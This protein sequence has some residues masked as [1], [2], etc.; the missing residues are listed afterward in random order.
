MGIKE[1][2]AAVEA[3]LGIEPPQSDAVVCWDSLPRLD[4]Q[5]FPARLD[6]DGWD[7]TENWG[8][9][10]YLPADL[11]RQINELPEATK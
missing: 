9:F 6:E 7:R 1:R 2:L 3:K 10:A 8:H 5:V 11:V 4:G